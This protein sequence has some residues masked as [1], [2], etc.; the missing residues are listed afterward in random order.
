MNKTTLLMATM[1]LLSACAPDCNHGQTYR[2]I[3]QLLADPNVPASC[4]IRAVSG[5]VTTGGCRDR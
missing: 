3:E 4:C 1:A 5:G 2:G